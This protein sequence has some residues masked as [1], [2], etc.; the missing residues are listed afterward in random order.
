MIRLTE[1]VTV[2]F[3]PRQWECLDHRLTSEC[4]PEGL[5]DYEGLG[6]PVGP[7]PWAFTD[8][9]AA[10][11]AMSE[12]GRRVTLTTNIDVAVLVD[13]A[14]STDL[15]VGLETCYRGNWEPSAEAAYQRVAD[16]A[17]AK[18]EAALGF[19]MPE[20]SPVPYPPKFSIEVWGGGEDSE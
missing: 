15:W 4:V 13:A 9:N 20:W 8:V 2:T 5:V 12:A 17:V 19:R 16:N 7:G 6:D 11:Y 14:M 18:V 3:T 10:V 1:P